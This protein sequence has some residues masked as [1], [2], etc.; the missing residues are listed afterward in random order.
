MVILQFNKLIRNKWVWG[1][2]A[3]A[4]S[5]A[6]CFDE[7]FR[8]SGERDIPSPLKDLSVEYDPVFEK[9]CRNMLAVFSGDT[10]VKESETFRAYAALKAF[11]ASGIRVSDARLGDVVSAG[12]LK[13][14]DYDVER[15]RAFIR[16]RFNMDIG[17]FERLLRERLMMDDGVATYFAAATWVSPMEADQL[18]HDRTDTFTVRVA[19]FRQTKEESDAVNVGE[20]EL[21]KWFADNSDRLHVP[22]RLKLRYLR[23]SAS[24][25][26]LTARIEVKPEEITARYEADKDELYT[27]TDTND[28]TTVVAEADV[29]DEIRK[30]LVE[31]KFM[32]T[33]NDALFSRVS[34]ENEIVADDPDAER[35]SLVEAVAKEN[36]LEAVVSD[37]IETGSSPRLVSGFCRSPLSL[38]PGA[39]DARD[40]IANLDP[41]SPTY[42]RYALLVA[43][44]SHR[45]WLVECVD[46]SA[47]HDATFEEA[48]AHIADPALRDAR[49]EAFKKSVAAVVEKGVEAVLAT[50]NVSEAV[51][52]NLMNEEKAREIPNSHQ[53]ITAALGLN[54]GEMSELVSI[55]P[56]RGIVV[57]CENRTDGDPTDLALYMGDREANM[58]LL[59][60]RVGNPDAWLD[61]NLIRLGFKP[62]VSSEEE[63]A[64]SESEAN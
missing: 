26:N 15:Y 9:N 44:K 46:V 60:N 53:V 7:L 28:V 40:L 30:T 20:E 32:E 62:E 12:Y 10:S 42:Y 18:R 54:P 52:F 19:N 6:F 21:K 56:G 16:Q 22:T 23:L 38:F 59:R 58:M 33:Y 39:S 14:F 64:D 24:D 11:D 50:T 25:T 45:V 51:S 31:E 55:G 8:D 5:A 13:N 34:L 17:Q 63:A 37:W 4:V 47:E 43:E 36:G 27:K 48:K 41:S 3:I 61:A 57:V 29:A 1:V 2:F 35:A 49:E